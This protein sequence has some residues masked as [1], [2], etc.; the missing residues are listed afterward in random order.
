DPLELRR[1]RRQKRT[2]YGALRDAGH[3]ETFFGALAIVKRQRNA[4]AAIYALWERLDHFRRLETRDATQDEIEELAAITALSDAANEFDAAPLEFARAFREGELERE[5]WLPSTAPPADAVALLTVHQAKGLEWEA[6]F[7]CDLIEGRFPALTRS[8]YALFDRMAFGAVPLDEATRA[9]RALEEERR[10]FYVAMTRARSRLALTATEE[11]REE[12]G[13]SL[14]RFYLEAQP[15]LEESRDRSEPVSA[16]EALAALRRAGGGPGGWRDDVE[17]A[18]PNRMLPSGGLRTSASRLA[19]YE[20]CPLQFFYG[21]LVEIDSVRTASMRLGGAFHDVLEAFHHPNRNEPQTLERLLELAREQS[22]EDVKPRPLGIEQ[23]RTLVKL[24]ENY[25][26]SEVAPGFD[27]EVLA[28]EQRFR[29]ELDATTVTGFID[30]IDRLPDAHLRLIDYKT[31]KSAM[32]NEEAEQDLQLALYALACREVPELCALGDVS[33]LVYM[34]P[35]HLVRGRAARRTQT[36]TPE[37]PD[38]TEQRIRDLVTA[39]T[40]E[41]FEFSP[42][43][44][45]TW[46]DFKKI[47]P[48]H[49]LKDVPL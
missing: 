42:T 11:A 16:A 33:E 15:F 20:N 23:S 17:T 40:S 8:Q 2:L 45:C 28:V 21:S 24:L 25:F 47:C 13:R 39:I 32:K 3:F 5:E 41:R 9:R 43:A 22:F 46:C 27:G 26:V 34:Y 10:L 36:I 30:R 14:S 18:N 29:F 49:H 7:V 1:F 19:P 4:G 44:D 35:R 48:R 6:V 12:S 37:L 31:S 38:R